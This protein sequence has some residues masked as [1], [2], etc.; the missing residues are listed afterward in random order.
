MK[1]SFP[2]PEPSAVW[3]HF[4]DLVAIPRPSK[5]EGAAIDH[6]EKWASKLGRT[7]KRDGANNLC[8]HVP[9]ARKTT[10]SPVILQ[11]HVDIVSVTEE[12]NPLG[13]DA[14]NGK[15]PM[16]RG[17]VDPKR[18][19]R[20]IPNPTGDWINAP[21]TTLGADN[22]I[23]VAM[24]MA[25]AEKK[26]LPVPLELLFT[27]DEEAGMTGAIGMNPSHLGITG[28]LLLNIDTEE[29]DEITIG[30]AGGRDV[31]V[32]WEGN[33]EPVSPQGDC[34]L[35]QLKI[36]ELKG[37]HSGIEINQGRAN[38]N[39]LVARIL[40]AI[41]SLSPIQLTDWNGGSRRNA[42][43]DKSQAGFVIPQSAFAAAKNAAEM[44]VESFNRLYSQRDNPIHLHMESSDV[45]PV[46]AMLSTAQS[47]LFVRMAQSIPTGICE[48]TPEL[49]VLVESSCNMA[50]IELG[51][52]KPG[53]I[54]CSVRGTTPEALS[55]VSDTIVAIAGLANATT[56]IADGYPGWKPHLD[57]PLLE[58]AVSSYE[59]LFGETPKVHAVHAGLECGLLVE[60]IPGLHAISLGPTIKGN[61]AVGERVSI[62]SVAKS[63]RYVEAI[64]ESLGEK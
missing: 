34:C 18:E 40:H 27:V 17:E 43:P 25:L 45:P 4:F 29:D 6:I 57:S 35:V 7:A 37:G 33:W 28:K 48:M 21:Y 10:A 11:C 39:R 44:Q 31:E 38:A 13:A 36:D 3:E 46:H 62:S 49:P 22:G 24:M 14:S 55:D 58:A 5:N 19:K 61:H 26:D 60:K 42:I 20:L 52:N 32:Q 12:G 23:G 15:I 16:E 2:I 41:Q 47:A 53:R 64:L 1:P 59:R 51:P 63:Y 30:S 9:A 50:I 8:V 54:V 56:L